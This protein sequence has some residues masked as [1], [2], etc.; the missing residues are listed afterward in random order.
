MVDKQK[1]K[2]KRR[3][4]LNIPTLWRNTWHFD[5]AKQSRSRS[6]EKLD[7]FS[8]YF[9]QSSCPSSGDLMEKRKVVTIDINSNK[10]TTLNH[11]R[12]VNFTTIARNLAI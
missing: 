5:C 9:G 2:L 12:F 1:K 4:Q 8:R 7:L 6:K 10:Q 11:T 3:D